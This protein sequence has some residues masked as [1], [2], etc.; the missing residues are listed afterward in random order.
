M[1]V[2]CPSCA[3]RFRLDQ[4]KLA[5]KRMTLRCARCRNHFKIE[6]PHPADHPPREAGAHIMI[7]HSDQEL[8]GT[9]RNVVENAGMIASIRHEGAQAL[10]A[11]VAEP[12]QVA[13]VDVALQG[14]YAFEVVDKVRRQP[15]LGMVKIILLSS[16]YNKTAYK[17]SPSS[18]YGADDY[19][20]KHH[21]AD[22]LVPKI[23]R[24]LVSGHAV[25]R[26][27][28][29]EVEQAGEALS[30][31]DAAMQSESFIA[32]VNQKIQSAENQEVSAAEI[33]EEERARRLARIIVSDIALYYQDRV[34]EG[35][36][37]GNWSELLASEI[38]EARNLF[39]N[40]FPSDEIQQQ[41]LLEAAF[42]DLF[43][44]RRDELE[45]G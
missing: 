38:K 4:E 8:C 19:I 3:A 12:P 1:I 34:D 15:G 17:R 36:R 44:K 21:I 10:Q 18:L 40:R 31:P 26:P 22:D 13:V 27:A 14:L 20:E 30:G 32:S 28:E 5:G 9:I 25:E 43:E 11:M 29:G 24:L 42:V 33:P 39:T 6:L 37:S 41:K 16:V 7:A 45:G 23:N 2:K 35:I